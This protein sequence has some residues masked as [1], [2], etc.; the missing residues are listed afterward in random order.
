M[1]KNTLLYL[2]S[3]LVERAKRENI[4][5]LR[6]TEEALKQALQIKVPRTAK[7]HLRKL[8]AEVGSESSFYGEAYLLP[9]QVQSLKLTNVGPFDNFE[10][11]FSRNSIN[12]IQGLCG[13]GKSTIIRSI[14]YAFGIKHKY[15]TER[16]IGEGTITM[17]LFPEQ[18]FINVTG[19]KSSQNALRGYQC[20]V[21]DDSLERIRKD[22]IAPLFTELR[23]LE[24]Q[25]ILTASPLIDASKLPND[26][27]IITTYDQC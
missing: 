22:M 24:I 4:N 14:L 6:L 26:I 15:F 10:A 7:E 1:K 8:L 13:S 17:K 9:F 27:R 5:I 20:L 2:D 19:M 16:V 11:H 3:D 25:I 21:A 18:D 12:L 23:R